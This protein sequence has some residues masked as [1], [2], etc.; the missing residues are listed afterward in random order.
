MQ[1]CHVSLTTRLALLAMVV[2]AVGL[3]L[4]KETSA[5][6]TNGVTWSQLP[7]PYSINTTNLDLPESA[8][9]RRAVP[10]SAQ[11]R[12]A[13][14]DH[15]PANRGELGFGLR[16]P[17][18]R[19]KDGLVVVTVPASKNPHPSSAATAEYA[20]GMPTHFSRAPSNFGA[21]GPLGSWIGGGETM[22]MPGTAMPGSIGAC[23][24]AWTSVARPCA[25]CEAV[26]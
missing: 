13:A 11:R 14:S 25:E 23:W 20:A 15:E 26:S 6:G 4:S 19:G 22:R 21:I 1:R 24:I 18:L 5:Y 17:G 8:H 16:A 7:V 2:P 12:G 9:R 3:V 10:V